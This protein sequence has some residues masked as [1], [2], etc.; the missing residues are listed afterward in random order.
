MKFYSV[1]DPAFRPYGRVLEGYDTTAL[2]A[3]MQTIPMPAGGTAYEPSIPALEESGIFDAMQNRAY[4]GMP[5]QIGMCW[6]YNT[7]LNCLEY[8][9]DSEVNVG[10]TDFVLLLAKQDEIEDGKLDTSKVKAFRVP[11]EIAVEVYAT[12]LHY[13]PCQISSEGFRVAVV[14]PNG[15]NMEKPAFEPQSEEDTWMTAR[16]KWLLAHPDSSEAKTGA[17]IGLTGKNIDI[18]EN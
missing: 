17:H 15:T 18:T 16:N 4:G 3:A 14:L 9:R 7:K 5:I 8:H 2:V 13:A 6:G 12:T 1:Y 10:E 11:A